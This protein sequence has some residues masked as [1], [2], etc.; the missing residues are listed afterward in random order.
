MIEESE[1]PQPRTL[2]HIPNSLEMVTGDRISDLDRLRVVDSDT[3]E[4][5]IL[6]IVHHNLRLQ[7]QKVVRCGG[8]GD[9]GRDVIAYNSNDSWV[10]Y[11]CKHYAKKLSVKDLCLEIGKLAHYT[12]QEEY[13]LPEKYYFVSP[14]GLSADSLKHI[15]NVEKLK[16]A[17]MSRWDKVCK[18]N[19]TTKGE[20]PLDKELEAH[21]R[22]ID[23]TIFDH[24][25][26]LQIVDL[27][28]TTP[29]HTK[30]FGGLLKQ[31]PI[32]PNPPAEPLH[33]EHT[34]TSEL[35]KAFSDEAK[36]EINQMNL[37]KFSEY[38]SEYRSA[39]KNYYYAEGLEKFSR[40]WL[41]DDSFKDLLEECYEAISPILLQ[42]HE[43]GMERYL[44]CSLQATNTDFT[45]HPLHHH[46]QVK[47]KKGLC[48]YL[49]NDGSVKWV[50]S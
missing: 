6:E 14:L 49:A 21:I 47:D 45:Q 28:S 42:K 43:H 2:N 18:T 19:I 29:Y 10:N 13:T 37:N 3:W 48:H 1:I 46:I 32:V 31:R 12:L 5:I 33:S 35:F 40:D 20:I 15:M 26:P 4:D 22:S 23:F 44:K 24:I 30:R 11:Q 27:H 39:R 25:P 34:Y 7:Y 50:K 36:M 38:A 9:M 16:S 8:A 41:P 17:V